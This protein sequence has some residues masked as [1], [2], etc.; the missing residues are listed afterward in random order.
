[1]TA[2]FGTLRAPRPGGGSLPPLQVRGRL[3]G[4][5]QP[6]PAAVP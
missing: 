1:M 6:G 2:R 3:D 4:L 5:L